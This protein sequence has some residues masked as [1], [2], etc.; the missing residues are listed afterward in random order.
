MSPSASDVSVV[1]VNWNGQA[2][3]AELLPSLSR[4]S[5]REIIVVD[6]G[7]T[8]GSQAFVRRHFPEVR[9]IENPSNRG[10]AEPCNRA[11]EQAAGEYV[12]FI[13]NDMRA[14]ERWLEAA[15][16]HFRPDTPCVASRILDWNGEKIDY[17]G[18]SLQY[19][20]YALQRDIGTLL[21]KVSNGAREVLF[22]CGGAMIMQRE[23]FLRLGG[24]DPDYFAIFED[25]DLGW[26][27]WLAGYQ[28][29]YVPESFVYHRGHATFQQHGEER[30]RYLM[31]RNALL[32]ICKNYEEEQFRRIFPLALVLAIKRAILF[33]GVQKES[34]YLWSRCRHRLAAADPSAYFQVLDALNHLVSL[35]D[36]LETLPQTLEKR[37][38]VQALRR[39]P[40]AEILQLF[41]DPLRAIVE[42]PSY[43]R[44]EIQY[45]ELLNLDSLLD[46][47]SH[48]SHLDRL[49]SHLQDTVH[50]LEEEIRHLRQLGNRALAHP[51]STPTSNLRK[52]LRS[53]KNEG[54]RTAWNRA[55]RHFTGR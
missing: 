38:R 10:F 14:D 6:N 51:P 30:L 53:W 29:V 46:L 55:V 43:L 21:E 18:S 9:L 16:P 13:N 24:F 44:E 52:F 47:T 34:F 41:Q 33:S 2:H 45:L 31:H 22:A 5:C 35:D 40:D 3:L 32:T 39:R 50:R 4:L 19:L 25:V 11:A 23:A 27:T 17:N 8:D 42:D 1:T 54:L 7:S 36:V 48:R 20:G 28:V 26:R 12:A 37:R 15:L 49:P